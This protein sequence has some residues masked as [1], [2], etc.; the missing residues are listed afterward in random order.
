MKNINWKLVFNKL[1]VKIRKHSPEILTGLGITGMIT[2]TVLAVKATPEAMRRIEKKKE[3][4]HHKTLTTVQTVQAAGVC[5]IPAV[6]TGAASI[7]CLVGASAV[8]ERRNAA[9]AT[10]Y[11]LA[12]T[13]LREYKERVIET[14]GEKKEALIQEKLD[15]ELMEKDIP[16][17]GTEAIL[18]EG[19]QQELCYDV[20]FGRYFYSDRAEIERVVNLVNKRMTYG[21][22]TYVS[23]N[24]FYGELGLPDVEIGDLVGWNVAKSM[25]E[26][27]FDSS[28]ASGQKPCLVMRF[29]KPPIY[30]YDIS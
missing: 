27:E 20:M 30:D 13:S 29:R 22:E 16:A 8:N 25:I 17:N 18:A 1:G 24:E 4:E 28:L 12:E 3:E 7:A 5:Y 15:T 2:T 14:I 19:F 21:G 23:L 9:L 10:A 11:G 26:V 6:V